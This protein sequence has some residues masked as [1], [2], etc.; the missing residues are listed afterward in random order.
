M[1]YLGGI[2]DWQF[3]EAISD[4]PIYCPF[5]FYLKPFQNSYTDVLSQSL[6]MLPHVLFPV[7]DPG[8]MIL[9]RYQVMLA[10]NVSF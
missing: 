9:L 2:S 8:V 5:S 10:S 4:S 7:W 6:S 1:A 3:P